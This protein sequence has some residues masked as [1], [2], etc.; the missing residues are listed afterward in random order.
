[1][2]DSLLGIPDRG[3]HDKDFP[4]L[5]ELAAGE[6]EQRCFAIWKHSVLQAPL[7]PSI[8]KCRASRNAGKPA[9]IHLHSTCTEGLDM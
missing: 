6:I 8:K 1:M 2:V 7:K 3:L 5:C 9:I 4:D